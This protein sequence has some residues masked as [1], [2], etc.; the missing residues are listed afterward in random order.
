MEKSDSGTTYI[1][2][3][4]F[5]SFADST[6]ATSTMY[7]QFQTDTSESLAE[8]TATADANSSSIDMVSSFVGYEYDEDGNLVWTGTAE[9]GFSQLCTA[10]AASQELTTKFLTEDSEALTSIKQNSDKTS[11]SIDSIASFVGGYKD[12]D[13]V[14][15][16]STSSTAFN[17]FCSSIASNN[18]ISGKFLTA[19]STAITEIKTSATATEAKVSAIAQYVTTDKDGNLITTSAGFE[20]LANELFARSDM[21]ASNSFSVARVTA[22]SSES[23]DYNAISLS[24]YDSFYDGEDIDSEKALSA[25]KV[26]Y[27]EK[28]GKYYK[29]LDMVVNNE[30]AAYIDSNGDF[31]INGTLYIGDMTLDAYIASV[32]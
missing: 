7:T 20:A 32:T 14:W 6:V 13:G 10:V 1:S 17:S 15:H 24:I 5:E 3:A 16:S 27:Y 22:Y 2:K 8:I 21:Y 29:A 28:K 25:F 9:T 11:S 12:D 18:A 4:G 30:S 31:Y 26:R 23:D 19:D